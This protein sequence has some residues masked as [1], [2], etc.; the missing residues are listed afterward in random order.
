M[1]LLSA[2]NNDVITNS[3]D[4]N[5]RFNVT[6]GVRQFLDIDGPDVPAYDDGRISSIGAVT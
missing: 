1:F 4:A 5:F 3:Y 2:I 6:C